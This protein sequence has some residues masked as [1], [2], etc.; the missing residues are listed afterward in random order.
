[1]N[2]P[3]YIATK[4][5]EIRSKWTSVYSQLE[6][7]GTEEAL[8]GANLWLTNHIQE[9]AVIARTKVVRDRVKFVIDT[10]G[11]ELIKRTADGEEYLDFRLSDTMEDSYGTKMP[12]HLLRRWADI[13]NKE[14]PVGDID[15]E[16]FDRLLQAGLSDDQVKEALS[17]KPGIAKAVQAMVKDGVLWVRAFIDKR[18]K[19]VIEKVK[20]ASIEAIVTK[21][22]AGNILDGDFLGFSFAVN[23]PLGNP[24]ATIA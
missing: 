24:R 21:D 3:T 22:D 7:L 17:K 15:H 9:Q 1:M 13:I 5:P 19:K 18:Y 23:Q 2:I 10:S 12:E 11:P 4:S 14:L 20:G 16:E 8:L 6:P